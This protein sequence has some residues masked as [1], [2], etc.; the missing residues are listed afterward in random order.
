M[1]IQ[2]F[3]LLSLLAIVQNVLA[4]RLKPGFDKQEYVRLMHVSAQFGGGKY[5]AA[6]APEAGY[7]LIY[8]SPVVGLE[9][10]WDLWKD[11]RDPAHT[12]AIISIRGTTAEQVSW[13]ANVYAA[14]IPAKGEIQLG[15]DRVWKYD[16]AAHPQ[17]AVHV[18]WMVSLGFME[19]DIR[20][21]IDSCYKA[22]I[23]D[24]VV[25]GHSQ[26]G[27]IAFLLTAYL[28]RLQTLKSLPADIRF[29]TYCSA[30][31]KPGNLYFAYEYEAATQGWAYN[32]VNAAD[33]VPQTPF[34]V[35]TVDD[36]CE[37]NP[38]N[39]IKSLLK[40]QKGPKRWVMKHAYRQL[41]K[42]SRKAVRNYQKYLGGFVSKMA[43]KSLDG[44][45][46][47][48]Y[49]NSNYYVRAG[50]TIPLIPDSNYYKLYPQ[51]KSTP[52]INH[53]HPP[54]MYLASKLPDSGN[55]LE[56]VATAETAA[57]TALDGT[58]ELISIPGEKL[59]T[60]GR[61]PAALN[62]N[63]GDGRASGNS[64][65]NSFSGKMMLGG[66]SIRFLDS[67]FIM[68]KMFCEGSSEQVFLNRLRSATGYRIEGATLSLL[69]EDKPVMLFRRK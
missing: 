21:K 19:Q 68:T 59:G 30:G 67:T 65:C 6:L 39:D 64:G 62:L 55:S 42:P 53:L 61:K 25:T 45:T 16:V 41:T 9:N 4:Q 3:F 12:K 50:I 48:A 1:K 27:A 32:V 13:L 24:V 46:A 44:F 43:G 35:Q 54:Y 60:T 10:I 28:Y 31:P 15:K 23:R 26:G 11:D 58:W 8:R 52:F 22:G 33:W 69:K 66:P 34:S 47:P 57:N 5:G 40:K 51:N 56:L 2:T 29:K 7:K 17:A 63:T 36:F 38:F 37:V 20:S 18:G 14:M 49:F